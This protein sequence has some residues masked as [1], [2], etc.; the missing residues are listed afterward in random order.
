[1]VPSKAKSFISVI[2]EAKKD[3]EGFKGY[4][5]YDL[6]KT[7]VSHAIP[8]SATYAEL[9]ASGMLQ[10]CLQILSHSTR[11]L[12]CTVQGIRLIADVH[13]CP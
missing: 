12:L 9:S 8:C 11:R 6:V 13:K 5:A 10:K 3:A 7:V 2:E 1:M 4:K